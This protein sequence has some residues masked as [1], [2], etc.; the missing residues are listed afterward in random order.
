MRLLQLLLL[1]LIWIGERSVVVDTPRPTRLGLGLLLLLLLLLLLWRV[2][3]SPELVG[4][5]GSLH[6]TAVLSHSREC[7]LLLVLLAI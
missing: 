3:Q 6:G 1:L 5:H 4:G 7:L 2:A